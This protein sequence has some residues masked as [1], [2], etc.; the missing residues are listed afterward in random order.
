MPTIT[1]IDN[2]IS[3][4]VGV[5]S[6]AIVT[7]TPG[8]GASVVV[9]Y[10]TG[11]LAN[12]NNGSTSWYSWPRGSVINPTS[13]A[14][15]KQM[16]LRIKPTGGSATLETNNVPATRSS[17][18]FMRDWLGNVPY[19][20]KQSAV[21]MGIANTGTIAT[22]GTVTLGTA[23]NTIYTGGIWLYF[24]TTAFAA[25]AAGFYWCVMSSTT[26]GVVYTSQTSG[27]AVTGSNVAYTGDTTIRTAVSVTIPG[28]AIGVN[29]SFKISAWGS[30]N[31][32]S[33]SKTVTATFGGSATTAIIGTTS[34]NIS[35]CVTVANKNS[36]ASQRYSNAAVSS[37]TSMGGFIAVDTSTDQAIAIRL[38]LAV[39]TDV[40]VLENYLVEIFPGN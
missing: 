20:L 12:I 23:L 18:A 2:E 10:N 1:T 5:P 37:T 6:G 16:F 17:D 22:N 26:V 13:Q 7:V 30:I 28:G 24:P 36:L 32:T 11:T 19:I 8:T 9:E 4:P 40:V 38:T 34:T 3:Q 21:P 15:N 14:T 29:G 33:G 27:V 25:S 39:A 31:N 35:N